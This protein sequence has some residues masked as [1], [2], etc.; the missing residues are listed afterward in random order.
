MK[1][2]YR[3]AMDFE[4]P[5][6]YHR[7]VFEYGI[8][9]LQQRGKNNFAVRY[10]KEIHA[11]LPYDLAARRLGEALMHQAACDGGVK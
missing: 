4:K 5:E 6:P 2:Y 9:T 10:G 8:I 3:A 1:H 11:E 7:V